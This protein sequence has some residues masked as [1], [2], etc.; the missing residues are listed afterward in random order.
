M[1]IRLIKKTGV[2]QAEIEAHQQIQAD[3]ASAPFS[4]N[5]RG[6]ASFALARRGRGSGDD[7]F[8]LVMVTHTNIVVVELKNWNGRV[9]ES[10]G[11]KWILDGEDRGSSPV[12]VAAL[13]AKK[14]ASTMKQK[15]GPERTPF[16]SSYVVLHGNIKELRLGEDEARSVL[17]MTEFLSFRFTDCYKNYFWGRPRFNPTQ[18]LEEY[19]SFFEG[20]AFKPKVYF[21]DGFRPDAEPIFQ[22]PRDVYR[23]Y[24]AAAKE[25]P[26][27]LALLRKW[28]FSALG[29]DLLAENDRASVGLREQRVYQYVSDRNEELSLGLL[30]PLTR[31]SPK[32][33]TLDFAELFALPNT[34][35]RLTEF[36]HNVLPKLASDERLLLVKAL[37]NRFSELHELRVAHR[38]IGD[39]SIWLDRSAKVMISGFPAAY[40]PQMQTVGTIREKVKVELSAL[41]EDARAMNGAT[42]YRRDVFMLGA[43][44]YLLLYGEK[45]PRVSEIYAWTVRADDPFGGALDD[46]LK[47]AL[48]LD[49]ALRFENAREMLEALNAATA[50]TH[51]LLFDVT[52]FEAFKAVTKERDYPETEIIKEDD[53]LLLF[54][55][56]TPDATRLVKIWYGITPDLARQDRSL[57]LLSFLERCRVLKGVA[58]DGAQTIVDFGLTRRSLLLVLDWVEGTSLQDWTNENP[59]LDARLS[60][61]TEL[62]NTITRLHALELAHGDIH[63]GNVIVRADGTPVLIDAADLRISSTD[64]YTTAYLPDDY[65]TLSPFERDR[66]GL[67]AVLVELF[68]SSRD[69]PTEGLF[70]IPR[71]YDEL[72]NLLSAETLSTLEPLV[73]ALEKTPSVE[74][75]D[76]PRFTIT[77][78]N[79]VHDRVAAG[80]M[81]QD[82][83]MFHISAQRDRQSPQSIR[84]WVTG[85]GRQLVIVWNL[86]E[87]RVEYARVQSIPQ[88]QLLRSQT[89]RDA[90]GKFRIDVLDGP[91]FDVSDLVHHILSLNEL[92]RKVSE[93]RFASSQKS[94]VAPE[95]QPPQSTPRAESGV[96]ARELWSSLIQAEEEALPTVTVAGEFRN[97]RYREGQIL[98]AYHADSGV[99][100]YDKSDTVIV[101]SQTPDGV[102]L[103][104]GTLNLGDTTFGQLAE[105]AIDHPHP[106]AN[107]R[108]GASLRLISV[109]EKGSFSRRSFAVERFL[110]KKTVVPSLLDYFDS[111]LNSALSPSLYTV[112]TDE[113]LEIYS[114]GEKHLND[115]QKESFRKVL[116]HGPVSL[117]QGPPGTGKT[118]FIACLLHYLITKMGVRR[119]L[120]VSQAH[121][122]V[123]N[124]LEK[125]L[126][127]CNS[128]GTPFHAVR[129]GSE[130]ATSENIRHFHPTSI[131]Q[132]YRERFKAERKER[133]LCLATS[134]GLP[135]RFSDEFVTLHFR[136]GSLFRVTEKLSTRI[137]NSEDED[138]STTE[139]RIR[140]L[141][142]TFWEVAKDVYQLPRLESMNVAITTIEEQLAAT[143]EVRST[144]AIARLRNLLRL[145]NEWIE[146]LGSPDANFSEFLAKTRTV[147][148]GTLVG[149]GYRA[150]GVVQNLF[151]WVIIDE[152]GRAAP[153]E[154]AVAMQAGHRILLVGDH[155]QL[156]PTFSEGV[157]SLI[158][159]KYSVDASSPLF[160]S[161]FARIFDSDYGRLVG[162]TL[163][164]QYRMAPVIGELVSTCFYG[165]RLQTGRNEPPEYYDFLPEHLRTE[166]SWIDTGSL[167]ARSAEQTSDDGAERWNPT[168]ARIMM[169]LLQQLVEAEDFMAFLEDDLQPNEPGIGIIC[170][171]SKQREFIDRMISEAVWLESRRRLV[172]VDTVDSYQ[173]KENRIVILSIVRNNTFFNP[174]FLRSPNRINV[175]MSR[176]MERLYIVGARSMWEIRNAGLP[177]GRVNKKVAE[178]ISEGRA[179]LLQPGHFLVN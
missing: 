121:E 173:G 34:V 39:H 168:E 144:D 45:P 105:L 127:L 32:D 132:S 155:H 65:E 149:I 15:L 4:K 140:A 33:V 49:P 72:A 68:G 95:Q 73:D 20:S 17:N 139:N 8:D 90:V 130:A 2:P 77:L 93:L 76:A 3:F 98:V 101:E 179:T 124:A 94:P 37:L 109:L 64:A 143:Y 152:A 117:L 103:Q 126:E 150:T 167:G 135:R 52:A 40:F 172:K 166:V 1:E 137:G 66:Y 59:T 11:H 100:D 110:E 107:L 6:Y 174:G 82:N 38:D 125:G 116:G 24:K 169:A 58:L 81:R 96:S 51:E 78:R 141:T 48:S 119:I 10:D 7:D 74:E 111:G 42:P 151:D 13:K 136:L 158:E 12:Q 142:E 134:L 129:L 160:D 91:A 71:V 176:A 156:P 131:E 61:G 25:D 41:P 170:M 123:N 26:N 29:L 14:L 53:S 113:D 84:L 112:P 79:P 44:A 63:P 18:Y 67:A 164:T 35:T 178:L 177:L 120:L 60:A 154:L 23:E 118:W 162:S 27:T 19:D 102:W 86:T 147:V 97:N 161:D 128:K 55:S 22:H 106:R 99:I 47:T 69:R 148:S 28:D 46:L 157:R 85:I 153:S 9:L 88:S 171:Y 114:D 50:D 43:L 30:R 108:I 62:A 92:E 163:L 165:G 146:S 133:L 54:K 83:G 75:T 145:S 16:V 21:V 159:R 87:D 70:P 36:T 56:V 104:C 122:A 31:K 175:A 89:M 115:S 138:S 5:W 80:E 57:R